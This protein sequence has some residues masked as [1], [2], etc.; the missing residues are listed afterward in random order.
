MVIAVGTNLPDLLC[1]PLTM[2]SFHYVCVFLTR[3]GALGHKGLYLICPYVLEVD[4]HAYNL[5]C[6][7]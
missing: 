4:D 2:P 7:E 5:C 1:R 3:L 6:F